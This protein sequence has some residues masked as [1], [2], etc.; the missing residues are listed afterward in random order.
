M[1]DKMMTQTDQVVC[2]YPELIHLLNYLIVDEYI[3]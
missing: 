3:E 1:Y 2:D